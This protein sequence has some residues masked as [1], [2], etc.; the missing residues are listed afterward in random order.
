MINSIVV[1]SDLCMG[2]LNSTGIIGERNIATDLF[3]K[4]PDFEQQ[5][6]EK[7]VVMKNL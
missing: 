5:R 7:I 6:R 2:V 3:I 4:S 1:G